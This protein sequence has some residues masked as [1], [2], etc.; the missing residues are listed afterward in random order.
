MKDV[1]P[2]TR[3]LL[4]RI[5]SDLEWQFTFADYSTIDGYM[6]TIETVIKAGRYTRQQMGDLNYLRDLYITQLKQTNSVY[7]NGK[8]FNTGIEV[9]LQGVNLK[10][11][12]NYFYAPYIP[13]QTTPAT[14]FNMPKVNKTFSAY[15][16]MKPIIDP[17]QTLITHVI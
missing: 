6:K 10:H 9:P 17:T 5:L 16:M 12:P 2:H 13:L 4:V 1:T 8:L 11:L 15:T 14:G 3:N 7:V